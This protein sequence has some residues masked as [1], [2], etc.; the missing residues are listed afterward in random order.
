M[1][2]STQGSQLVPLASTNRARHS[3]TS[4]FELSAGALCVVWPLTVAEQRAGV[5]NGAAGVPPTPK[6]ETFKLTCKHTTRHGCTPECSA[7]QGVCARVAGK[8]EAGLTSF[9][10]CRF[11]RSF[12]N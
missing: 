2:S 10:L 7:E 5:Y 4:A 8:L 6:L 1:V 3:L 11:V 12:D 9:S